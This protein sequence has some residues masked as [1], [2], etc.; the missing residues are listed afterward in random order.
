MSNSISCVD[1]KTLYIF[2]NAASLFT[3]IP[4]TILI[5]FIIRKAPEKDQV[6]FGSSNMLVVKPHLL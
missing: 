4:Y 2:A 5:L 1:I 3:L 6:P